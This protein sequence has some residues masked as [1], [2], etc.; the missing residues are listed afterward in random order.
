M[1]VDTTSW[2]RTPRGK[3]ICPDCGQTGWTAVG[4]SWI[5][6]HADHVDCPDCGKTVTRKGLKAHM[7]HHATPT[8]KPR[9]PVVEV[10][11]IHLDPG[12]GY[13]V[14]VT[15]H[16]SDG[17]VESELIGTFHTRP[18]AQRVADFLWAGFCDAAHAGVK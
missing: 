15:R 2:E 1:S 11:D 5:D 14:K 6:K 4:A 10:V 3:L 12:R 8:I 9:V 18:G 16:G 13:T 17:F 7:R